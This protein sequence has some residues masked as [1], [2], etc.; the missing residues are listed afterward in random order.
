MPHTCSIRVPG[1]KTAASSATIRVGE[2]LWP[3]VTACVP[4]PVGYGWLRI[5]WKRALKAAGADTTLRLHDLR[6]CCGQWLTDAG[7]PEA[8]VEKTLRH[9]SPTMTR[10]YTT[11]RDRGLDA[12]AMG[13][14]LVPQFPTHSEPP[15][16]VAQ[17]A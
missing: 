5:Y 12:A 1:S 8:S 16:R 3:W 9:A 13:S 10:R 17:P 2:Q 6:H 7:R 11:Q 14:I 4:A 15:A